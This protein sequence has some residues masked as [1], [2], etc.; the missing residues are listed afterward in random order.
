MTPYVASTSKNNRQRIQIKRWYA[1]GQRRCHCCGVQLIYQ[2]N[3][4]NSATFEHLVP[5][6]AG[7]TLHANNGLMI[8]R[9]CN[10]TRGN[11]CWIKFVKTNNLPKQEWLIRRYINAV[12]FYQ[13]GHSKR[14]INVSFKLINVHIGQVN[15]V[16]K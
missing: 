3:C 13:T 8:C 12:K 2:P 10:H 7:G 14:N 6:S 15:I 1:L 9:K 11:Q 16:S 4:D 5:K